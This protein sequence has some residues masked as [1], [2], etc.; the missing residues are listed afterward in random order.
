MSFRQEFNSLLHS[1]LTCAG[2]EGVQQLWTG[3]LTVSVAHFGIGLAVSAFVLLRGFSVR[4]L[5]AGMAAVVVKEVTGDLPNGAFSGPVILDS[6]WDLFCY[7]AGF[8]CLWSLLMS[9]EGVSQ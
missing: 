9:D 5:W 8:F 3:W 7:L 6:V 4:W 2:A 1:D